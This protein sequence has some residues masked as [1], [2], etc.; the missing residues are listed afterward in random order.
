MRFAIEFIGKRKNTPGVY[1]PILRDVDAGSGSLAVL[2]LYD[3]YDVLEV[4]DIGLLD[5]GTKDDVAVPCDHIV[6]YYTVHDTIELALASEKV[7][8]DYEFKFCPKCGEK[9]EE[10]KHDYCYKS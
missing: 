6:G 7:T 1:Y 9:L 5:E 8:L 10:V 2:K 3:D 4:K